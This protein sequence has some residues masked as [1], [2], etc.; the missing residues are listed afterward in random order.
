[1]INKHLGRVKRGYIAH[2]VLISCSL[3][4]SFQGDTIGIANVKS[5]H[6]GVS[7][8][9]IWLPIFLALRVWHMLNEMAILGFISRRYGLYLTFYIVYLMLERGKMKITVNI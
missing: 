3:G 9:T 7:C 1:M 4:Y 6:L 8:G 2:L 5:F